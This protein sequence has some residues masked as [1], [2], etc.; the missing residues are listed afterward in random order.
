[1]RVERDAGRLALLDRL[2]IARIH[3]VFEAAGEAVST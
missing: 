2:H 1:M 3:E